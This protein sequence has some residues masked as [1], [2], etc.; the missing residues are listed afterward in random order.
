MLG[1]RGQLVKKPRDHEIGALSPTGSKYLAWILE[2][3]NVGVLVVL[4]VMFTILSPAFFSSI[5]VDNILTETSLFLLLSL[6]ETFVM[7]SGGIDISVGS[8]LGLGGVAAASYMSSH[9]SA[10]SAGA[11]TLLVGLVI[12]LGTGALGGLLNGAVIAYMGINP[13]IVTLATYGGFL[14]VADLISNGLPI[15]N[16]PGASYTLGD[17]TVVGI[18]Y[19]VII[20]AVF[21]IVLSW[22]SINTRFGRYTFA[23]GANREAVRRAG[24]NLR[25]HTMML[26]GMTGL[27]AGLAGLLN[28]AHFES[29]TSSAGATDLLVAIAAVVI[30]G[31]PLTGGEGRVWG[32][33]IG[34]LIYTVLENGFVL[35]GVPAFWQL[36]VVAVLIVLAVYADQYQRTLRANMVRVVEVQGV[37]ATPVTGG[38]SGGRVR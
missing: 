18:P 36:V 13:L 20:A 27:L 4:V 22:M 11:L 9:Y 24:V 8:M 26:Y 33:V 16:L 15:A 30:G 19:L 5:S 12:A 28:A 25:K 31:T 17:G 2:F 37:A 7:I 6:G 38:A 14:G 21:T 35:V 34:A 1:Q 29:A 32:T 23:I 3:S 10:T